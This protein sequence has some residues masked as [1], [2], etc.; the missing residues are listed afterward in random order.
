MDLLLKIKD[1]ATWGDL[2][3]KV[4]NASWIGT[5]LNAINWVLWIALILVGAC[6][7]FTQ[8]MLVLKWQEQIQVNNVKNQK[9]D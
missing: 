3:G 8:F 1:I 9:R 2:A 7:L 6:V 5:L 4:A